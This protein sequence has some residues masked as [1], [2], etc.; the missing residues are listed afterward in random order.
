MHSCRLNHFAATILAF[1]WSVSAS[2]QNVTTYHNDNGRT[3]QNTQELILTT[4]NV[5][6]TN[7]G[8]L[9]SH[10]VDGYSY[11]QPLY[12]H[13]VNIP[14]KGPHNVVYVATMNNSVYA[15]DADSGSA[16]P[17]PLWHVNFTNAAQGITTVPTSVLHCADTFTAQVGIMST[18][19]ID[20][21][22]GT[23]YVLAR[24]AQNGSY[25]HKL[26]A[27]N[28]T[29]GAEK[30]GGPVTIKATASGRGTGSKNGAISFNSLLEAQRSALL[31]QNGQVYISWASLCDYAAYHGWVMAYNAQTLA[32]TAVWLITPNG[33]DGGV[34][35]AGNGVAGDAAFNTFV[36]VGN[37]TFDVN[38][39]GIDY[40]QSVVKLGPPSGASFP[41][42]DYF[43]PF[44]AVSLDTTDQDIGSSGL[45]L[46]P[47][48]TGPFPH[49]LIQGDK[50]GDLYLINRDHMGQFNPIDN[51]N[52]V[53]FLPAAS[54]GMWSSPAWWN[55][56]VYV[57]GS[58][59]PIQAFSLNPSTGLLSRTPTSKTVAAYGYP[60]TT[61]S[62]SSNG[63]ANGI[64]WALNNSTYK[65]TT[66]PGNLNAYDATNLGRQLY[67]S[68][69]KG[70]R[71]SPG[72]PVKFQV[73]TIV[74]GKV[75]VMTQKNLVVYG[76]LGAGA[77]GS[78]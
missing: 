52:I 39:T 10:A 63:T 36:A 30:F 20:I 45:T 13:N 70:T 56:F 72:A 21:K 57:G 34:W 62:I 11:G 19:V 16:N 78:H 53:Q 18:P 76:L 9:F 24:T 7:F 71:D 67:S 17:Q 3:G 50:M 2:A 27:L 66:L 75:Y 59:S 14:N 40:G 47:D 41:I 6:A 74:N 61:V 35:Q 8:K 48:Q 23:L 12:V 15:F 37:G 38:T 65:S 55:N 29:T 69:T 44:N 25:F 5:N 51:S 49:L 4:K 42:L 31:L 46:L 68:K 1:V 22:T 77:S 43:T 58:G 60:G 64:V 26:H 54:K 32:Q 33:S 28:I 73:P